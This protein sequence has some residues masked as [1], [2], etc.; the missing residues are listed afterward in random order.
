MADG[1]ATCTLLMGSVAV[2]GYAKDF[3]FVPPA[4][5]NKED[6]GGGMA[7]DEIRLPGSYLAGERPT[8]DDG[9]EKGAYPEAPNID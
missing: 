7:R 8:W 2:Y 6:G 3:L 5:L 4:L 9:P 1:I